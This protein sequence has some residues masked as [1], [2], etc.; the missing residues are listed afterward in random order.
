MNRRLADRVHARLATIHAD[1]LTRTLR[2]PAGIDLSSNDYLGLANDPRI[3]QALVDAVA[4]QGVGS[5]GS[6]LLRGHRDSFAAIEDRFARFKGTERALYFSSGY[7]ANL[8]LVTTFAEP[9]DVVISDA[10]NHASLI[11]AIRLSAARREIVPHNDVDAVRRRIGA[12]GASGET[13]VVV[14]SLYS[15]EGDEAPLA[16]LAAV[17]RSAGAHLIVDEAHAVG[18]YG[19]R[20]AGLIEH[21]G[22]EDDVFLSI[23]AAGKALGVSGA[24][25]CGPAWA[26]EYL[27]QRA[28]PFVFSTAPPPALAAAL[29]ASLDIVLTE[30]HRRTVLRERAERLRFR[31]ATSGLPV[32]SGA[33]H[34]VPVVIGDNDAALTVAKAVQADGFD[35]RA[36]RPPSVPEGTA[37]LRLSVNVNVTDEIVE[38]LVTSLVV[39]IDRCSA[40]S[41]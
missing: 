39:A 11:D 41:L 38:R 12:S 40:A 29:D 37:R 18:V 9:G 3:K 32:A 25:V 28:R 8:A 23:D 30:P 24:F 36:I 7:L 14:E 19:A 34:I 6:R 16:D 35:V 2:A 13:F 21:H 27:I 1:G 10:W 33:S 31:L 5:T 15:M 17:C 26:I 4:R 22:I 20:G